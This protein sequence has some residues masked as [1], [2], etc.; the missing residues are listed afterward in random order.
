MCIYKLQ[1]Q[2]TFSRLNFFLENVSCDFRHIELET[3]KHMDL[4]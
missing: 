4:I 2:K 3:N 1:V